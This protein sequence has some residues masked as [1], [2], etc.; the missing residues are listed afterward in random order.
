M[1]KPITEILRCTNCPASKVRIVLNP[2]TG[3]APL[4]LNDLR[5]WKWITLH[6]Y[7][8]CNQCAPQALANALEDLAE[9]IRNSTR[10]SNP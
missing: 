7:Y 6:H 10:P 2:K 1:K 5:K 8:Y 9:L 4:L 3:E